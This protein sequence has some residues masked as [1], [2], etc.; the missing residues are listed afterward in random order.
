MTSRVGGTPGQQGRWRSTD[1]GD[2]I[3]ADEDATELDDL[4]VALVTGA[5][6]GL[7]REIA[8]V[9]APDHHLLLGGRD[10]AAVGA[11]AAS[12]PSAEPFVADLTDTSATQDAVTRVL[13]PLGRLDVLVHNAGISS[14]GTVAD[15]PR[16]EWRRMLE[17]NVIAVADL[18]HLALSLLRRSRG[19][20]VLVNSGAGQSPSP[21]NAA[22]SASKFALGG[23]AQALREEERGRVRVTSVHPGR[24]DTDM[25]VALQAQDGRP[26]VAS[27]HMAP[28][29]VARTVRLAVD[30]PVGASV[31]E[32][33]VRPWAARD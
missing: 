24:I 23:L 10:P 6:R 31:E 26:Y 20:V 14:R 21:G 15:T 8:R 12:L 28:A 18:T 13:E 27:E 2:P 5:S 33:R 9:L 7:G 17:V 3:G 16:E 25:Q 32:L 29:D 1:E 4:P 19:L 11:L 30:M 22:Y